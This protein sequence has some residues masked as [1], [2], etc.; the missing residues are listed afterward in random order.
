MSDFIHM[1]LMARDKESG[2]HGE[3][4][5]GKLISLSCTEVILRTLACFT[6]RVPSKG[7]L[8][9]HPIPQSESCFLLKWKEAASLGPPLTV[10]SFICT[11]ASHY[12][13]KEEYGSQQSFVHWHL[14]IAP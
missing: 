5:L 13:I 4:A 3:A 6:H 7:L 11:K 9:V 12:L 10:V 1:T 8:S 2:W 14:P